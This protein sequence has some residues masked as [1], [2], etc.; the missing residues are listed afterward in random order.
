MQ[1]GQAH[2]QADKDFQKAAELCRVAE[3][4]MTQYLQND[5]YF[6]ADIAERMTG[7]T[8]LMYAV[9]SMLYPA[10]DAL[11]RPLLDHQLRV[12][13]QQQQQ[14]GRWQLQQ[15]I[16]LDWRCFGMAPNASYQGWSVM[17]FWCITLARWAG[18]KPGTVRCLP[19][20]T[21]WCIRLS[22]LS[23][24]NIHAVTVRHCVVDIVVSWMP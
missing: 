19:I 1:K 5:P 18:T 12:N 6:S 7:K 15:A 4:L 2:S 8:P 17:H 11:L 24:G 13:L 10:V 16:Q 21:N 23:E 9:E 20:W 22:M 3:Y 14:P